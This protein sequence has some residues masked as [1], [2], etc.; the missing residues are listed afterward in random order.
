MKTPLNYY[1]LLFCLVLTIVTA[2]KEDDDSSNEPLPCEDRHSELLIDTWNNPIYD[3]VG[4]DRCVDTV[5]IEFEL[6]LH[7][8]ST[9]SMDYLL[10]SSR[11]DPLEIH[12]LVDTGTYTF[13][14]EQR[15]SYTTRFSYSYVE[16]ILELNSQTEPQRILDI[17]WDGF[18]GLII[19][20]DELGLG[21][22]ARLLLQR[23]G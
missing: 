15:G 21:Y 2:C 4:L 16:G 22:S 1:I 9:Y 17:R 20:P 7:E 5:C 14:C 19:N 12:T 13:I 11:S 6:T 23:D 18:W 8:D 10:F 3:G